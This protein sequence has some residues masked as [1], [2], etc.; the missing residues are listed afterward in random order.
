MAVLICGTVSAALAAVCLL[1]SIF[2]FLEKGFLFNNAY[3]WASKS[4]RDAMN[5]KPYY[6]QSAIAFALISAL[7]FV[8][9]LEC[10]LLTKW[11]WLAVGTLAIVVLIYVISSSLKSGE[12]S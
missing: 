4:E 11:L 5:K 6:K 3:I 9:A 12:E 2:Q 8:M 1:I 7:L 10:F